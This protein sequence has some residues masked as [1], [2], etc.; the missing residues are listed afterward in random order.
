MSTKTIS[1]MF[2]LYIK[3]NKEI[4][5]CLLCFRPIQAP[6]LVGVACFHLALTMTSQTCLIC[7]SSSTNLLA[8]SII[9]FTNQQ[10]NSLIFWLYSMQQGFPTFTFH[11][12]VPLMRHLL[13]LN[14]T[15]NL[16]PG[17]LC[18]QAVLEFSMLPLCH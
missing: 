15:T 7:V 10:N 13:C 11:Q 5:W 3:Q 16:K 17:Q 18:H 14:H 9:C 12:F 2:C 1:P 8:W 6:V 4:I